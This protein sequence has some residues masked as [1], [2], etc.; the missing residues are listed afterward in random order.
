MYNIL[1][2]HTPYVSA[3]NRFSRFF[4]RLLAALGVV[5]LSAV[6]AVS[7]LHTQ[8]SSP[9]ATAN[10]ADNSVAAIDSASTILDP[11]WFKK[12][13]EQGFELYILHST[14][15][16]TCQTWDRTYSQAKMALDAGLKIAS[17]TRNPECY[18][19]G[20]EALGPLKNKLQFFALDIETD[21]GI[22]VARAM[23]GGVQ[24]L[25]VRP[26]IYTGSGM[27][28]A[29]MSGSEEFSD[30]A[31]WDTDTLKFPYNEWRIDF[32]RP[33]PVVYGG[34]NTVNTMRIG[35]QQQF[36]YKLNGILVDLNSFDKSFLTE[37]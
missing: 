21:P 16:G 15:W 12:A 13:Y 23:V 17:Y 24:A 8:S 30:V 7:L 18:K 36:E 31:L 10:H 29:I 32:M 14:T 22:P 2:V 27:W 1:I 33:T 6:I 25:G 37:K 26:V 4:L 19:E 34:W 11:E 3:I 9:A 28:P 5:I 35:I 20:I